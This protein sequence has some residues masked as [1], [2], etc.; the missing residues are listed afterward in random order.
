MHIPGMHHDAESMRLAQP[1]NPARTIKRLVPMSRRSNFC[2]D[3]NTCAIA[4]D[5]ITV[6]KSSPF[7]S[8][9]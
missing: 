8:V 1:Q 4:D 3:G 6:H 7:Q 5:Q 9:L 2:G